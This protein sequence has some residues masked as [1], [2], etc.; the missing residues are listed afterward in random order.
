MNKAYNDIL[1]LINEYCYRVDDGDI[2]GFAELFAHASFEVLGSPSGPVTGKDEVFEF[3]SRV[4]LYDGKPNTKHCVTNVQIDIDEQSGTAKSQSYV[5]VFQ[6]VPPDFPLQ[7][8][9]SG[10]YRDTFKKVD[11]T[12]QFRTREI[13]PDLV[14]DLSHAD[15]TVRDSV[16][17]GSE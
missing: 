15:A 5:T 11:D 4:I 12:W 13:S 14:G 3:M 1:Y 6:A 17:A 9:F 16:S 8:V 7:V 2:E 10:H